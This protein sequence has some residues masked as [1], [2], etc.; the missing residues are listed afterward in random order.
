MFGQ[1]DRNR[2]LLKQ[3]NA[4]F[5]PTPAASTP[6]PTATI[7]KEAPVININVTGTNQEDPRV[8]AKIIGNE[9]NRLVGRMI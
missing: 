6:A 1:A 5:T 8:L 3:I 9:F 4:G 7:T 2:A